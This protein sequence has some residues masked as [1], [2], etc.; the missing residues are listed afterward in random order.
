MGTYRHTPPQPHR[1]LWC[2]SDTRWRA[3]DLDADHV[4]SFDCPAEVPHDQPVWV[5]GQTAARWLAAASQ[6]PVLRSLGRHW[7]RHV[8]AGLPCP[9]RELIDTEDQWSA[10]PP[11]PGT[12]FVKLADAKIDWFPAA[13]RTHRQTVLDLAAI[14]GFTQLLIAPVRDYAAEVRVFVSAAGTSASLYRDGEVFF[15]SGDL[16]PHDH[17]FTPPSN[18]PPGTVWD[19]GLPG[20]GGPWEVI[21]YNAPWSSTWYGCDLHIVRAAITDALASTMPL[22]Q[23]DDIYLR[24]TPLRHV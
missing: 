22:W 10:Y 5:P 20:G 11:W 1:R 14:G 12:R 4:W 2:V 8:P 17:T 21:E 9:T 3:E 19:F 23:P 6:P 13:E 16:D 24:R 7:P 15:D 18:L